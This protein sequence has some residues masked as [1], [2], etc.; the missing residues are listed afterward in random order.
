LTTF[1]FT[2]EDDDARWIH[3]AVTLFQKCRCPTLDCEGDLRGRILAEICRA[4]VDRFIVDNTGKPGWN[5]DEDFP[6]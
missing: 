1:Q 4:W 6:P 2:V 5:F 3:G